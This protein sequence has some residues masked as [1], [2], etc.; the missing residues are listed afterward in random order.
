MRCNHCLE[1]RDWL[2]VNLGRP[3]L[4]DEEEGGRVGKNREEYGSGSL[5]SPILGEGRSSVAFLRCIV[6]G[7]ST[8]RKSEG[9]LLEL[10]D[11]R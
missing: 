1:M 8:R 5:N 2:T 7:P 6:N 3:N 4:D 11:A 9:L 10:T